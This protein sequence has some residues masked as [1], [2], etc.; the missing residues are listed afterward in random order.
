LQARAAVVEVVAQA[1]RDPLAAVELVLQ[2]RLRV[3][4]TGLLRGLGKLAKGVVSII[5]QAREARGEV[6]AAPKN[7]APRARGGAAAAR[8]TP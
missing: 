3:E 6:F 2:A 4:R 7:P 1:A 5:A 8:P